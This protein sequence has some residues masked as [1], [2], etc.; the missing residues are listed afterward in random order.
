MQLYFAVSV[1]C[2]ASIHNRLMQSHILIKK[3]MVPLKSDA[4]VLMGEI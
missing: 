4:V 2:F 3:C 1:I